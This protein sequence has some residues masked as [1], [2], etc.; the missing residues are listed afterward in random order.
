MKGGKI[1]K[2]S[3]R[4]INNLPLFNFS[5]EEDESY[6]VNG[7]VSHNCRCSY[8]DYFPEDEKEIKDTLDEGSPI[9]Q[10]AEVADTTIVNDNPSIFEDDSEDDTEEP[11][12]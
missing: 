11:K 8:I 6:I 2:I 9:A 3:K 10:E 5:V 1:L 4:N 7:V 12:K